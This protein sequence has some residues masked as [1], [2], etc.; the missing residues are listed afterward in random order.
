MKCPSC[1]YQNREKAKFCKEC[2]GKLELVCPNCSNNLDLESN[3]C[4]ECGYNLKLADE[5]NEK[6][7]QLEKVTEE[8]EEKALRYIPKN[9]AEKI[10]NNKAT[11]EGERKQV[12]VLFT[13]VSGFTA[14]SEKLDPEEVRTLM[15]RCFEIIIEEVHRYEG[16]VN[17]FTGDGV[18]ALFGAPVALEDH[19]HRAVSSALA[20]QRSLNIYGGELKKQKAIDLK[21]KIG[22]NTGLVVVG[23]IGSDLRMDYTAMGDTINLASR[24]QNLAEPATILISESTHKLV[25]DYFDVKPLGPLQ[26]KGKAHPVKAFRVRRIKR[27]IAPVDIAK[28]RGLTKLIGRDKELDIITDRLGKINEGLGQVVGI[29]G[30]A[31]IGKSRLIYEFRRSIEKEKITYIE[32]SCLSYGIATPYL[33]IID[34]IKSNCGIGA[35]DDEP[36]IKK[37]LDSEIERMDAG[38][39]WILPYLYHLLSLQVPLDFLKV[40][41]EREKKRRTHEALRSLYL[42]GSQIRPLVVTIENIN[43]MDNASAEYL[44]YLGEGLHGYPLLLILTYRPGYTQPFI[45]KSYYT[46]ISL[47]HL[48]KSEII[49]LIQELL[50][51]KEAPGDFTKLITKQAEGN[52]FFIEELVRSFKEGGILIPEDGRYLITKDISKIEIPDRVQNVIM[53]RIDRLD[54]DLKK[55]LQY[56]SVIGKEFTLNLLGRVPAIGDNLEGKLS[57]LI[58]LEFIHEKGIYPERE[59]LFMQ[60]LT[61]DVAYQSL[62]IKMRRELHEVIG[63]GIKELYEGR[64]EEYYTILAHHYKNSDNKEQALNYLI[65]AGEKASGLYSHFEAKSYYEEALDFLRNLTK[66]KQN[67][68]RTIDVILKLAGELMFY[69]TAKTCRILL[70]EA[71]K[72]AQEL[73]DDNRLAKIYYQMGMSIYYAFEHTDIGI[74]FAN[75]CLE[76]AKNIGDEK[77]IANAYYVLASLYFKQGNFPHA[78]ELF[79][80]SVSLNERI[81]NV[82]AV[83]H[84]LGVIGVS[85]SWMGNLDKGRE[86]IK[87]SINMAEELGDVRRIAAGYFYLGLTDVMYGHLKEGIE[88]LQKS[89]SLFKDS[90]DIFYMLLP[91]GF[92][93]YG[94]A[95]LGETK[96]GIEILEKNLL[97]LEEKKGPALWYVAIFNA[98][99][100]ESYLMDGKI[101]KALTHAKKSVNLSSKQGNKF[102]EAHAYQTLGTVY[103]QKGPTYWSKGKICLIKSIEIIKETGADGRLPYSYMALGLLYKSRGQV[104]KAKEFLEKALP[105]FENLKDEENISRVNKELS[106]LK[107]NFVEEATLT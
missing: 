22:I 32:S 39:E 2:G 33:P 94:Y 67:R 64:L 23:N 66:N 76:I 73:K 69:E 81:E 11:L 18:M 54:E 51:G 102:E 47:N 93:G 58:G 74:K 24:L 19:P 79:R 92:L 107:Q 4:D 36:T 80:E 17:Q 77:L 49:Q 95:K 84:S 75:R 44:N 6:P 61:Q 96:N 90:G 106:E 48:T 57:E 89:I 38:L 60:S 50:G 88:N 63:D 70:G 83:I 98:F 59:Y 34:H 71:E 25:Q 31:G 91:T 26:V 97:M 52:P 20:I 13:D 42:T 10:L 104:D 100:G 37:K 85:Y 28:A 41:D 65:L 16:T 7:S 99:L 30:E 45:G 105:L 78:V 15:N 43:W 82:Q 46:Q 29:V 68:I 5:A 3:F 53:A 35:I 1:N 8:F 62:L 27:S 9:L 14:L 101:S 56:A 86:Y 21:I 55:T 40:L 72:L 103:T 87:K 12:T